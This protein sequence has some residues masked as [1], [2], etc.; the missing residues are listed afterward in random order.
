MHEC[1]LSL[2][3]RRLKVRLFRCLIDKLEESF[4]D[5]LQFRRPE[6]RLRSIQTESE[7]YCIIQ[8]INLLISFEKN[9]HLGAYFQNNHLQACDRLHSRPSSIERHFHVCPKLHAHRLL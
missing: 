9:E 8:V 3:Q 6:T 7:I 4:S 5:V 1:S 2:R